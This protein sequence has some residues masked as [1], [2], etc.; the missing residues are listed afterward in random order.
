M[1]TAGQIPWNKGLTKETDERVARN[2]LAISKVLAGNHP[3]PFKGKECPHLKGHISWNKGLTKE[4]D[5]RVAAQSDK[6]KGVRPSDANIEAVRQANRDRIWTE[7]S[8]AKVGRSGAK[9]KGRKFPGRKKSQTFII[10]ARDYMRKNNPMFVPELK[11]KA[12]RHAFAKLRNK[13]NE[14]EK[15]LFLLVEKVL[16]GQFR[17]N[18]GLELGI[19]IGHKIPDFVNVNGRKQVI[20]LFGD[21]WHRGQDS[22]QLIDLYHKLGWDCLV[23]WEHELKDSTSITTKL[24]AFDK[25]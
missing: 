10:W 2:G 11:E 13:Q 5:S 16:P 18:G 8:R 9:L 25:K 24:I 21:Y 19:M 6:Q 4:T 15:T 22:S 17:Y 3:S 12:I 20:E 1:F 23:V 14:A 7:E